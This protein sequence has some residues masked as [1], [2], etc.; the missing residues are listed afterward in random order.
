LGRVNTP[1]SPPAD[2]LMS[3]ENFLASSAKHAS[4]EESCDYN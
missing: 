3:V 2:L 1:S 4:E